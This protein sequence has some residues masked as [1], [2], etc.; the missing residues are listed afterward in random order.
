MI[1]APLLC[2]IV[3]LVK[4]ACTAHLWLVMR[5]H[6]GVAPG[7]AKRVSNGGVAKD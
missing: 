4:A 2:K 3:S 1:Y 7:D 6:Q 5:N